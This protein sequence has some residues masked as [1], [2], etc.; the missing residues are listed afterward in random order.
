MRFAMDNGEFPKVF[1]ERNKHA[2]FSVSTGKNFVISWINI[3]CPSPDNIVPGS[4]ERL[5]PTTP[6]AGIQENLHEA[7][8]SGSGSIRS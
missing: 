3:P 7:D 2:P 6:H 1:I 5:A 4:F 8:S